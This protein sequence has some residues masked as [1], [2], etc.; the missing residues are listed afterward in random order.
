M[1]K[2]NLLLRKPSNVVYCINRLYIRSIRLYQSFQRNHFVIF[3][4]YSWKTPSK[5]NRKDFSQKGLKACI[6]E[7]CNIIS[8]HQEPECSASKKNILWRMAT[9]VQRHQPAW[10][11]R[12]SQKTRHRKEIKKKKHIDFEISEVCLLPTTQAI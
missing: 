9:P 10:Q 8:L 7:L 1:P 6:K 5:V 11:W 2:A 3:K 4:A 12:S